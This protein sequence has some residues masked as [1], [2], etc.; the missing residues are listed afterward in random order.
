LLQLRI[1]PPF[2]SLLH[3]T[4]LN[5]LNKLS[6]L[7]S[8]SPLSIPVVVRSTQ[9]NVVWLQPW[10]SSCKATAVRT[11][12]IEI[13]YRRSA[14]LFP[15]PRSSRSKHPVPHPPKAAVKKSDPLFCNWHPSNANALYA[16]NQTRGLCPSSLQ[17]H[18]RSYLWFIARA[19]ICSA[20]SCRP[21]TANPSANSD[22]AG[23]PSNGGRT[24]P[25]RRSFQ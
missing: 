17:H 25:P 22:V 4:P 23:M 5:L 18:R 15:R 14:A 3:S 24:N 12:S 13:T 7:L 16:P 2:P 10:L 9:G 21:P 6:E 11:W 20:S 8:I 1:L 19:A